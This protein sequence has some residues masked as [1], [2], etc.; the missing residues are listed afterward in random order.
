MNDSALSA[1]ILTSLLFEHEISPP[2]T[3]LLF[4]QSDATSVCAPDY[5]NCIILDILLDKEMDDFSC[6]IRHN[7]C[8]TGYYEPRKWHRNMVLPEPPS[9]LLHIIREKVTSPP[10]LTVDEAIHESLCKKLHGRMKEDFDEAA[11]PKGKELERLIETYITCSSCHF[12]SYLSHLWIW[13]PPQHHSFSQYAPSV[14]YTGWTGV[15]QWRHAVAFHNLAS[16]SLHGALSS[17]PSISITPASARPLSVVQS[18]LLLSMDVAF[19]G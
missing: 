10:K 13:P 3:A 7:H 16:S 17:L 5:R 18:G 15:M 12:P 19:S 9:S 8:L 14:R 4:K 1:K 2:L 6:D 11:I